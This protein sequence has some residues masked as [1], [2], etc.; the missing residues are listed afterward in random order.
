MARGRSLGET[1]EHLMAE[2]SKGWTLWSRSG[3]RGPS[4]HKPHSAGVATVPDSSAP[5]LANSPAAVTGT[6]RAA[7]PAHGGG[8][9]GGTLID[10]IIDERSVSIEFQAVHDIESGRIVAFE[11]LSH[12]PQG[13]LRSPLEL[14]GAARAAGRLGELDWVCR[15][16]AF[17]AMLDAGRPPSV[18]LLVNVE[19]DSLIEP[20]PPD[21]LPTVL[22]AGRTLRVFV[23]ITGRTLVLMVGRI[24]PRAVLAKDGRSILAAAGI[25][26]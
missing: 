3:Y 12:G 13:P 15:A 18:S 7:A 20:C 2:N 24:S 19:A 26:T 10:Q 9:G 11:A 21:L 4:E 17:R 6:S 25:P 5:A 14:F 23:D 22:D 16:A 1:L 8:S